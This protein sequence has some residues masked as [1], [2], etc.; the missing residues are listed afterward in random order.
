MSDSDDFSEIECEFVRDGTEGR[1]LMSRKIIDEFMA[2]ESR[3]Q[4]QLLS[5]LQ[6][7][8][9]GVKLTREQFNGNEGRCGGEDDRMLVAVKTNKAMKTRLYGFVR[10]YREKRTLLLVAMDTAKKQDKANPRILKRAK[11]EAVS[12]DERCGE[13]DEQ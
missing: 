10:H 11:A 9:N 6:L 2:L 7:W 3:K 13:H 12:L 5:R 8:G 4:A 1:V